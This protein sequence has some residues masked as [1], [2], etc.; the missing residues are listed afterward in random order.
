MPSVYQIQ[1]SRVTELLLEGLLLSMPEE[2]CELNTLLRHRA[3]YGF[4][5][6]YVS[7]QELARLSQTRISM[8]QVGLT[9]GIVMINR[10]QNMD[11]VQD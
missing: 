3:V 10:L 2:R 5:I 7:P 6:D 8:S 11:Y 4:S 1:D 9:T